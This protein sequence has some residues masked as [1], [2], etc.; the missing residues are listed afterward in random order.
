MSVL[1]KVMQAER[2]DWQ[3]RMVSEAEGPNPSVVELVR[4]GAKSSS[5][6]AVTTILKRHEERG[7]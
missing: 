7:G 4:Q 2:L 1:E 6:A 3:A 5:F